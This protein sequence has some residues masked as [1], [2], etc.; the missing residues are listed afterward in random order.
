MGRWI[1]NYLPQI[2]E[3]TI[4]DEQ[5]RA[6]ILRKV[7]R[8]LVFHSKTLNSYLFETKYK[9]LHVKNKTLKKS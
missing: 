1:T 5:L 9:N 8:E 6:T 2:V 7:N 4:R 3:G